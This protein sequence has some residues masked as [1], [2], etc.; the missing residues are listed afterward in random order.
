MVAGT[1]TPLVVT[2]ALQLRVDL[3]HGADGKDRL[4][5]A[6]HG[7]GHHEGTDPFIEGIIR[8]EAAPAPTRSREVEFDSPPPCWSRW[9]RWAAA[10]PPRRS[11]GAA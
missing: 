3:V 6:F 2:I 5:V 1:G 9:R 8:S 10:A 11:R 4:R 7:V